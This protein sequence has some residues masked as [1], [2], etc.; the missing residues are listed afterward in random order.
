MK[1]KTFSGKRGLI[2]SRTNPDFVF[3]VR[4]IGI[5]LTMWFGNAMGVSIGN[6]N[7]GEKWA[8]IHNDKCLMAIKKALN[9]YC[10]KWYVIMK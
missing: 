1:L 9:D 5:G 2:I 7:E 3:A 10:G 4:N 6:R 8:C